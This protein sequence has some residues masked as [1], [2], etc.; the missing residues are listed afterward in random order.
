VVK[1][2]IADPSAGTVDSANTGRY[3]LGWVV[4]LSYT[5]YISRA[6]PL[7]FRPALAIAAKPGTWKIQVIVVKHLSVL[8]KPASSL[9]NMRCTYCFYTNVSEHR[10]VPSYGIMSPGVRQ[11]ILENIVRNLDDRDAITL[12]FQGGEPTLAGLAWYEDFIQ[13]FLAAQRQ[14]GKKE[15]TVHYALQTNGLL[16]DRAWGTF[17]HQ[18]NFLVGLSLDGQPHFHNRNRLD[19]QG[20]ETYERV[21]HSKGLLEECGVEYNILTVLTNDIA[22]YPEKI[23]QFMEDEK[24]RYIQFIPCM[25]DL[26]SENMSK[27]ALRPMGFVNFYTVLLRWW[28]RNLE[29]GV[30]VSVK[31][32]DDVVN[33]FFKGIPTACG[34]DGQCHVQ[35]IVEADGGVYPCDFYVLDD[36]LAGNLTRQT[37]REIFETDTMRSFVSSPRPVP[38]VCRACTYRNICRGGCK[39]MRRVMYYGDGGMICGYKTFL[40]KCLRSLEYAVTRF[41]T[42]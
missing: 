26:N 12:A 32:F 24:I 8:I 4:L 30:Y 27:T 20:R 23:C 25:E 17:L 6:V 38:P 15:M 5:Q 22:K 13:T 10:S 28:I 36:Y 31:F 9:C 7:E 40:D 3:N 33:L 16:L 2:G 34:I 41:I 29:K 42:R 19:A 21:I 35:Y 1:L 11:A 18:Y 14:A 39:R 37:L